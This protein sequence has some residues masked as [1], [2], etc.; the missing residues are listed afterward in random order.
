[1]L[2]PVGGGDPPIVAMF[3]AIGDAPGKAKVGAILAVVPFVL[4]VATLLVWIP[5]PSSAG[6]KAI[7]WL[8]ILNAVY[9][10]YT[11]MLVK[12]GLGDAIKARPNDLL[13]APWVA[14]AWSAF[15]GYGI[16]TIFGKNLEHS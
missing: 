5:P 6:A 4:A 3:Q 12:G 16:A 10:A 7:A 8:W 11:A 13:M 2:V 9:V 1:M 15:I 14:A